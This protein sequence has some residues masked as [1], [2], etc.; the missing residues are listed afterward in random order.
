MA[1]ILQNVRSSVIQ[2]VINVIKLQVYVLPV[3]ILL[4]LLPIVMEVS[5]EIKGG[6]KFM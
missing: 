1:F 4:E 6:T 2:N 5:E 3:Q